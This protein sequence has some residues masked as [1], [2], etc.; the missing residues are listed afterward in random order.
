MSMNRLWLEKIQRI[1][2]EMRLM[3]DV[4]FPK[5]IDWINGYLKSAEPN[6][7]CIGRAMMIK[8]VWEVRGYDQ[9]FQMFPLS[10]EKC[11]QYTINFLRGLACSVCESSSTFYY[12]N[13]YLQMSNK[14]CHLF[15]DACGQ[16]LKVF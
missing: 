9:L 13:K 1:Y 2:K 4:Y 3:K 14:E 10:I 12:T 5:I 7:Q 15:C 11:W 6:P 16:H 8:T